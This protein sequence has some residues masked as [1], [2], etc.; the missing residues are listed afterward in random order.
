MTDVAYEMIAVRL[1][2]RP[3]ASWREVEEALQHGLGA[4]HAKA[5]EQ[6][7]GWSLV[8]HSIGTLADHPHMLFL[9]QRPG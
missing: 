8:S 1:E 9:L 3:G 6:H 7:A 5:S 4:F 2:L